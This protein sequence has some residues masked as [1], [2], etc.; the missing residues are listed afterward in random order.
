MWLNHP[1][2]GIGLNGWQ[3][4]YASG[5]YHP[6]N[7]LEAGQ[8]MPHNVFVYFLQR[9]GCWVDWD[10]LRIVYWLWH[11]FFAVLKRIPMTFLGS[12]RKFGG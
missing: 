5:P 6:L 12:S 11:I 10:T 7:S 8:I 4:A 1:L 2:T 9:V 3:A